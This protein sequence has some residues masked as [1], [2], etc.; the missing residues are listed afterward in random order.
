MCAKTKRKY[1]HLTL[2]TSENVHLVRYIIICFAFHL[3]VIAINIISDELQ[4]DLA[5]QEVTGLSKA[6]GLC[7]QCGAETD[8]GLVPTVALQDECATARAVV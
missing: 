7:I 2:Q 8:L 5:L 3:P 6:D 4:I 1:V